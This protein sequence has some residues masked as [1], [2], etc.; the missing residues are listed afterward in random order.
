MKALIKRAVS[1]V[2]NFIN[3]KPSVLLSNVFKRHY[4]R[5][6]LV[7]Y[8]IAPFVT[9]LSDRHTNLIEC[10]TACKIFDELGFVVDVIDYNQYDK[11]IDYKSYDVIYGFGE[12]F[13]RLFHWEEYPDFVDKIKKIIYGTGCDT[14]FSNKI[15]LKRVADFYRN[16]NIL[17]LSSARLAPLTWRC[18]I[19]FADLVIALGN[20]FVC[21]TYKVYN[22][23]RVEPIEIFFKN[24]VPVDLNRKD[25]VVAKHNFLWWGSNGALHKGLDLVIKLFS[26]RQDINIFVCGYYPEYPF[27]NYLIEVINRSP[28][29]ANLGFIEVGSDQHKFLLSNCIA[30][31]LPSAS[32]G[33]APGIV[34]SCGNA[35]LIPIITENCGLDLPHQVQQF[36]LNDLSVSC[37]EEKIDL[38]LSL[39]DD[40]IK[41]ISQ[42]VQSFFQKKHAFEQ[43]EDKLK[44]YILSVLF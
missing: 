12:S 40:E 3:E 28:N 27:N 42:G 36:V 11:S 8:I 7:S 1:K 22:V 41:S 2:N 15:S 23:H 25:F 34:S 24:Y 43:Y 30:T 5:R 9:G 6:V 4:D 37:L 10:Y 18:Q 20:K 19:V 26:K 35:G 31:I 16:E 33:G 13:E 38:L 21:D 14:V 17:C 39:G 29:I 44:N 32:E